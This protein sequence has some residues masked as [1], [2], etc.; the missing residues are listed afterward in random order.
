MTHD[1]IANALAELGHSVRLNIVKMSIQAGKR[2]IAVGAI[3]NALNIPGSTLTHHIQRLVKVDL[4]KQC[5]DK[6][7]RYCCANF[8][9]F[10]A[11]I[12]YLKQD[13]CKGVSDE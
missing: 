10:F 1:E 11:V 12:N 6:Q 3:K 2:G 5:R 9:N 4:I 7:T 8:N 13:C